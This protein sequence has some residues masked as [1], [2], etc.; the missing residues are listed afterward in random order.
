MEVFA[1]DE[2]NIGSARLVRN[3]GEFLTAMEVSATN[4]FWHVWGSKTDEEVAVTDVTS[5]SDR[6]PHINTYPK[7]YSKPVVGMMHETMASFQVSQS[8]LAETYLCLFFCM[9]I[10]CCFQCSVESLDMVWSGRGFV[11]WHPA[12]TFDCCGRT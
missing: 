9:L 4:R 5:T 12:H 2:D 6:P 8:M 7:Q 3:L 11:L 10:H 1:N